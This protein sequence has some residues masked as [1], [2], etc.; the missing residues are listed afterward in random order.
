MPCSTRKLSVSLLAQLS[1]AMLTAIFAGG[2]LLAVAA[3][4]EG[5]VV[6]IHMEEGFPDESL[7]DQRMEREI[8]DALVTVT[9]EYSLP[10]ELRKLL[11]EQELKLSE[12]RPGHYQLIRQYIGPDASKAP[13]ESW[14]SF[15]ST[16]TSSRDGIDPEQLPAA[17]NLTG[18]R[19]Y[20]KKLRG[21]AKKFPRVRASYLEFVIPSAQDPA[22]LEVYCRTEIRA[23]K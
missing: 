3:P 23:Q 18:D 14:A 13:K 2:A 7:Y 9:D 22:K 1:V 5:K 20:V 15:G 4:P 19:G 21:W 16:Y 17:L 11:Q 8:E 10:E 12:E 6:E